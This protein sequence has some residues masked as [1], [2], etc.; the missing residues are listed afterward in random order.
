[1]ATIIQT[2]FYSWQSDSPRETNQTGIK[3]SLEDLKSAIE[4][5]FSEVTLL[6]DEATRD[7]PGS[8]NIPREILAKITASDIFVCDITTIN[9]NAQNMSRKTANP[10]VLI[11]LGYAVATVG[12]DRII[13]LFNRNVGTFPEDLPFD[14][15]RHRASPYSIMSA[16]DVQGKNQLTSLLIEAVKLV[17]IKSPLRPSEILT[18]KPEQRK[19]R[20]DVDNLKWI[21]STIHINT[22]DHF[23]EEIPGRILSKIFYFK[24]GFSAAL[25]SSSF[26]LYDEKC[27]ELLKNLQTNWNKAFHYGQHYGTDGNST[28]AKF[29]LPMDEFPSERARQDFEVLSRV[30]V[31]LKASFKT[32]LKYVRQ[33]YLEIDLEETSDV[34]LANYKEFM[35]NPY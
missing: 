13:M 11:E 2:I 21:L 19:R 22:F 6:L 23:L 10:N 12:W 30:A 25:D 31:D 4:S 15:D 34:A 27:L 3:H 20:K 5:E 28:Y 16:K 7:L 8:P 26:H 18:E 33:E 1:M 14:I 24:E 9:T 35:Q 29:H 17:I 32:L